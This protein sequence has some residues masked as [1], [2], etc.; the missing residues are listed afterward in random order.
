MAYWTDRAGAAANLRLL[1]T[2]EGWRAYTDKLDGERKVEV[3]GS[4]RLIKSAFLNALNATNL[5]VLT[6]TGSS[7][8]AKNVAAKLT[9]AG[10]ADVWTAVVAKVGQAD[11][12]KVC[13]VF[14]SATMDT[15]IERLLTLC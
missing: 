9:P 1:I 7:F 3:A 2:G 8:D 13:A 14:S 12:D 15:N 4:K 10:M 11:F 5:I 6:G